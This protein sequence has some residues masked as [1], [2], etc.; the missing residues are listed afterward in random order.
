MKQTLDE[1]IAAALNGDGLGSAEIEQLF[2]EIEAALPSA[3]AQATE[4]HDRSLDPRC[5]DPTA[6]TTAQDFKHRV[7]RLKACQ[8]P[9][10]RKLDAVR[11]R[12]EHAR[13]LPRY[14]AVEA[15]GAAL[16]EELKETYAECLTK[17]VGLFERMRAHDQRVG[18]INHA[19]PA[20]ETRRLKP[21]EQVAGRLN[22]GAI[23][24][25]TLIDAVKLPEF[26]NS[27]KLLWPPPAV[28]FGVLYAESMAPMIG[29]FGN[30]AH[31]LEGYRRAQDESR[32][33]DAE[34]SANYYRSLNKQRAEQELAA[35]LRAQGG[36][37]A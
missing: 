35:R 26:E 27:S 19:A 13:W 20:G 2:D 10:A 29:R 6:R 34:Y 1:R 23:T 7:E 11:G 22:S 18:Q 15:E 4:A 17:L 30:P 16:A 33:A 8:V 31:D 9:L 28:P 21:V 25:P 24:N 37:A 14:Q 32:R 3:E 12:E 5:L 36:D